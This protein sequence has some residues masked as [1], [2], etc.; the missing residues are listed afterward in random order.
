MDFFQISTR[1]TS[2]C[3]IFASMKSNFPL[4]GFLFIFML[5][6]SCNPKENQDIANKRTEI[7]LPKKGRFKAKI[8]GISDGDTV[9]FL[10]ENQTYTLRLEHIDA[11]E[12]KGGQ[13]FSTQAKKTL[14]DLCFRQEVEI[15]WKGE[16][17]RYGRIIGV[18]YNHQG[19]NVN[20]EMVKKGMAWH[21][22]RYS[23]DRT[24]SKLE[25][26]ARKKKIGLWQ[27]PNPIP[28]WEWRK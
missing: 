14:S 20:Q 5:G 3:S 4:I 23:K 1:Q 18:I 19:V 24:Y 8:I 9:K 28:P 22:R 6:F 7:S 10:V 2:H 16:K 25:D 13:A 26:E 11:P 12:K 21:Y 15:E 27:D 17:D